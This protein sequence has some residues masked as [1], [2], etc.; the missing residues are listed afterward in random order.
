MKQIRTGDELVP[1][2]LTSV[3]IKLLGAKWIVR[4]FEHISNVPHFVINGFIASGITNTVSDALKDIEANED[5][6]TSDKGDD[7]G[8]DNVDAVF[9][10]HD[11]DPSL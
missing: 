5:D 10:S 9:S 6:T 11:V 2:N 4:M 3:E 7:A 1:V 8:S